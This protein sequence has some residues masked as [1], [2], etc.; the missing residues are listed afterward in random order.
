MFEAKPM[1][2]GKQTFRPLSLQ[3]VT[4]APYGVMLRIRLC[5]EVDLQ[6]AV[7]LSHGAQTCQNIL[8]CLCSQEKLIYI[9]LLSSKASTSALSF[10]HHM[11]VSLHSYS[12]T[13]L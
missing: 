6:T 7:F 12:L 3:A 5:R 1:A 2:F 4:D 10:S 13:C 11:L 8:L 9:L